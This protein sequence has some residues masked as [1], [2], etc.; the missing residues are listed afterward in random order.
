MAKYTYELTG[1]FEGKG[2]V[3]SVV[4]G[5]VELIESDLAGNNKTF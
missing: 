1:V 3:K 2:I 4:L 5:D